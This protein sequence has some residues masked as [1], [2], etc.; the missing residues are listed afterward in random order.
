MPLNTFD[1]SAF[2]IAQARALRRRQL[3]HSARMACPDYVSFRANLSA[4]ERAVA[5]LLAEEFG[6]QIAA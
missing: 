1:P 5:L 4:I 3:W 2:K 6:D